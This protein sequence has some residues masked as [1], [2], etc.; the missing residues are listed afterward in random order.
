MLCIASSPMKNLHMHAVHGGESVGA[1]DQDGGGVGGG[2]D[3][4]R[5][6]I[7]RASRVHTC[8]GLSLRRKGLMVAGFIKN[9]TFGAFS[10]GGFFCF[11]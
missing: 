4:I 1:S 10:Q 9:P 7:I 11:F 6:Y 5:M 8:P 3:E 2:A